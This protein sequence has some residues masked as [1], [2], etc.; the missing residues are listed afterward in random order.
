MYCVTEGLLLAWNIQRSN[1]HLVQ[2]RCTLLQGERVISGL[3]YLDGLAFIADVGKGECG[4]CGYYDPVVA[5]DVGDR[6]IGGIVTGNDGDT[7]EREIL[8]VGDRA[9]YCNGGS[10]LCEAT[11][12]GEMEKQE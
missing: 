9:G 3:F 7:N 6:A 4:V 2:Y 12:K 5:V 10:T 1:K 8:A 11:Q